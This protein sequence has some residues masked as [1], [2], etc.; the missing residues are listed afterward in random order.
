L[1]HDIDSWAETK[2]NAIAVILKQLSVAFGK[3][4]LF[5]RLAML[6]ESFSWNAVNN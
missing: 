6:E 2:N 5:S 3:A 1:L 4:A